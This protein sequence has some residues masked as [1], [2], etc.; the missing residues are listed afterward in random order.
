MSG[1]SSLHRIKH[2]L[3]IVLSQVFRGT[4]GGAYDPVFRIEF[5]KWKDTLK[6]GA[7]L[8]WPDGNTNM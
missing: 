8:I 2:L 7:E 5:E 4:G 3:T 1:M 6:C